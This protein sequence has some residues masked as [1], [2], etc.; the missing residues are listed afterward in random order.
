[1]DVHW[2]LT[3]DGIPEKTE[4]KKALNKVQGFF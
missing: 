4:N 3:R 2:K 1:M